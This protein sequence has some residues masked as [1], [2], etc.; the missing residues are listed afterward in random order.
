[1]KNLTLVLLLLTFAVPAIALDKMELDSRIHKL[2][3]K[4]EE[5]QRDSDHAIPIDELRKARAI[6]LLDRTKAGFLFAFQGGSGVA[7]VKDPHTTHWSPAAFV[8]ASEASL[9]F[10]VGGQQSFV[11]MLLMD[12][13]ALTVLTQPKIKFGGEAGGTAGDVSGGEHAAFSKPVGTVRV[14]SDRIGVFGGAAVNG[15]ALKPDNKANQI[16]Y[17][18]FLT[19]KNIVL[20]TKVQPSD[21]TAELIKTI[22]HYSKEKKK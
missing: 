20:E 14:Y 3:G 9:G 22:M 4:F 12:T 13:N 7:L 11:V 10:Q 21:A 15:D 1:M 18:Q 6:I 17:G 8:S 5:L 19:L 2:T 16:Y